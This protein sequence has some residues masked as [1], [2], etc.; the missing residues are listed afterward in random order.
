MSDNSPESVLAT[1]PE[2]L[3]MIDC[4]DLNLNDSANEDCPKSKDSRGHCRCWWDGHDPCC[5]CGDNSEPCD[6]ETEIGKV[7]QAQQKGNA[8]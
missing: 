2:P 7:G 6:C 1:Y 8:S 4:G 3:L 5:W